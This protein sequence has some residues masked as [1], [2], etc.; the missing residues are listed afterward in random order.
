M[1]IEWV[2]IGKLSPHPKNPNTH[3]ATQIKRLV[4]LIRYQGW[5]HPIIVSNRSGHVVAGHGRLLAAKEMKLEKVP[6]H[7]QEFQSGEQEYAFIV[8]DNAIASWAELDLAAINLEVPG[9]GPDFDID[10]LGIDGFEIDVAD[11]GDED[12]VPDVPIEAVSRLG[13]LYQLGSHRLLCGDSTDSAQVSR[14][15]AGE[16]A[17]MVYSD[18]PYGFGYDPNIKNPTLRD[19]SSRNKNN[20]KRLENDS[21][22]WDFDASFIFEQFGYCDEI[23]LWGAD[24]YHLTLPKKGGW[25]VWDKTGAH[26]S[27]DGS[28]LAS[29]ELC[30]SKQSHKRHMIPITWM[31]CFGHTPEDGDRKVHPTQKPIK[32]GQFFLEKWSKPGW[33]VIDHYLGSGSTLIACEKT[34]RRCF[35]ME[36][37]PHYCDVIVQRWEKYTGK[38]AILLS[39]G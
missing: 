5:R 14:L 12:D 24:Y 13:D 7:Y 33:L 22:D 39:N 26:P 23:F 18:P 17:D 38:K 35:G 20:H 36:I 6:V 27:M 16:R 3:S 2:E 1:T 21:G 11:R 34:N 9:L 31:G 30:W 29:F 19:G 28:Y 32:L 37:D 15:M 4:E 10:L 25:I 8:S